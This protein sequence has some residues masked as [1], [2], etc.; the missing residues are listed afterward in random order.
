MY[1]SIIL[2]ILLSIF[3][4]FERKDQYPYDDLKMTQMIE[5]PNQYSL[6]TFQKPAKLEKVAQDVYPDIRFGNSLGYL[7]HDRLSG[8]TG[9]SF[10]KKCNK[11][12]RCVEDCCYQKDINVI[13][14]RRVIEHYNTHC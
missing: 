4:P 6:T 5:S 1:F 13:C 11:L 2:Y 14:C 10:C 12:Y 3:V 7:I 8:F 9:F